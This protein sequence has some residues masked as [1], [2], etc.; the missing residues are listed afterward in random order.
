MLNKFSFLWACSLLCCLC[1]QSVFSQDSLTVE[2]IQQFSYSFDIENSRFI[3][4][5]AQ[6][7][8]AALSEAHITMLGEN[9]G[10]KLEHQFTE[11][12]LHVLDKN[13]YS[14]MVFEAGT[15]TGPVLN[16]LASKGS[17]IPQQIKALNQTYKIDKK[18]GTFIPILDL[19]YVEAAQGFAYAS[20]QD[21][22]F[23]SVGVDPWSAYKMLIDELY[24][25]LLPHNKTAHKQLFEQAHATLDKHYEQIQA[26]NSDEVK[27]LI[28]GIKSDKSFTEFLDKMAICQGN[29]EIIDGL[30]FSLDFYELYGNKD[31]HKK[32]MLSALRDKVKL[33]E[34]LTKRN[35]DFKTDKLFVKMWRMH[36]SKGF[37]PRGT[38]GVGNMLHE[39]A[40][41]H[42]NKSLTI[43]MLRRHYQEDGESK[44]GLEAT[45][46]ASQ[47]YKDFVQVGKR[48]EWVLIDLRPFNKE[49]YYAPYIINSA[50]Y[51]MFSRYD[52]LVIPKL[53]EKATPNY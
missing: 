47:R 30:Q 12:L 8:T 49:F 20:N 14:N 29:A 16:R 53:D 45:D 42:G 4:D 44:D 10:S 3:G 24:N 46:V 32:N 15:A 27:L 22:D 17:Q 23:Y 52:M 34:E 36:L 33:N 48:D 21:W 38:F 25:N 39:M 18:G 41:L 1:V 13:G 7:L 5:G 37:T 31:M 50:I 11:A 6:V 9:A 51:K 26:H 35:F 28:A 43:G 40:E 19:R 2:D